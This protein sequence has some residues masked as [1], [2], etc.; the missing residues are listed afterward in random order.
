MRRFYPLLNLHLAE[1]DGHNIASIGGFVTISPPVLLSALRCAQRLYKLD[2]G[3]VPSPEV[4]A[5]VEDA[6][7]DAAEIHC[8]LTHRS[9]ELVKHA[10][11]YGMLLAQ[12]SERF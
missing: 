12:V 8:L 1:D 3:N 10:R 7:A 5:R 2:D 4:I 9:K 6:A 11:V